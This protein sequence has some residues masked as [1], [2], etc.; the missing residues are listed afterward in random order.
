MLPR[1]NSNLGPHFRTSADP[2]L[3]A[4]GFFLLIRSYLG[5]PVL[6]ELGKALL[7]ETKASRRRLCPGPD[8]VNSETNLLFCCP[9]VV[10]L[11]FSEE[12]R[13]EIVVAR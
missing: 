2:K 5:V 13:K 12:L 6:E 10:G 3:P 4:H 7:P 8:A 11:N 1:S 9:R